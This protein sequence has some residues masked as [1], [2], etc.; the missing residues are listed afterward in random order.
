MNT[1]RKVALILLI[2]TTA[3]QAR[4]PQAVT[5]VPQVA[6]GPAITGDLSDPVWQR[7]QAFGGF[8]LIKD[9]KPATQPTAAR[10][11]YDADYL[12]VG[13]TCHEANLTGIIAQVKDRDGQV[14][15]DDCIE[16]LLDTANSKRS[17][18]HFIVN[19]IG[20]LFDE[21]CISADRGD[22]SWD[23]RAVVKTGL[24]GGAWTVEM[25]IPFKDLGFAPTPGLVWGMNICRARYAGTQEFSACYPTPD[26]FVQ[27]K[28]FG[29]VMLST[30]IRDFPSFQLLSWG[31]LD[32]DISYGGK[33]V[34]RCQIPNPGKVSKT[35]TLSLVGKDA[36]KTTVSATK[37]VK[38]P[39]GVLVTA[40]IPYSPSGKLTETFAFTIT[41]GR[42][43]VFGATHPSQAIPQK[44]RVW[45]T[46]DPLFTELLSENPPGLQKSGTIYW[47]HSGNAGELRPFA[48]EYGLRY[49]LDEAFR[50]LADNKLMPIVMTQ[51]LRNPDW[52]GMA[53]KHG[54]KVLFEPDYRRSHEKGVPVMDGLPYILDPRSREVYL[55]DLR[56]G[57]EAGRKFIWGIYTYDELTDYASAQ[58]VRFFSEQKDSY[59]FIREADA[60]VKA[61]F[62]Y[63]K[64]GIPESP[65]DENP[66]RWIAYHKW[67][68]SK[69][70]EWQKQ[71]YETLRKDAPEIKVISMDPVAGHKPYDLD[72]ITPYVDIATHQLYPSSNPN[73]QEFGFVTKFVA[74]LTGKPVWPCTHVENYA[75]STTAE[76]VRE[77]MSQVMRNGGKGFHLYIPDVRG[78]GASSGD[79]KLTKYGS[80]ERYRAIMEILKT[81]RSMNEVAVPSDA[82]CAI[83]YSEDHYQSFPGKNNIY[84]NEVEYCYT[85]LG[86]VART[87]FDI[88]ND[89]MVEDGKDLSK[90]KAIF[91]PAARYER[92][93]VVEKLVK[94]AEDGGVLVFS[95]T[96]P[97]VSA[98]DGSSLADICT[99]LTP[100][101]IAADERF[102]IEHK[103]G[104]GRTFIFFDAFT[105]K[106]I[107]DEGYKARFRALAKELGLK[108]D[109]DIWRFRFLE[110]KTVYQP[111]PTGRCLTGNYVKWHQEKPLDILNEPAGGVYK[112][113]A[114][115]DA[116]SDQGGE[117]R[118]GFDRGDLTDRKLAPATKKSDLKPEDFVV[119]WK[120]ERP[121]SVT[122]D[123]QKPYPISRVHL[124]YSDQLPA[125]TVEG[126]TDGKKWVRLASHP[127]QAPTKDV[128]D[129]EL[130]VQG[131]FRY[132]RPSF[133]P[134]DA[135]QMMTLVECEV[136]AK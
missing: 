4:S 114:A 94:Y 12:Y 47:F 84:P 34:L 31:N 43:T 1:L 101:M 13:V 8:R 117:V 97:F 107:G 134:R 61:R 115:P 109:R 131:T 123:L 93:S 85:L 106:N 83:L 19:S 102:P 10:V 29:E 108:T 49:S 78:G 125:L 53:E 121:V 20:T 67:V 2:L 52:L 30:G 130:K 81:S 39:A 104:K 3:A 128:L 57:L 68:N 71:V 92:R 120:T 127:K 16:F 132:V 55:E 90:Y 18:Y 21:R 112:Y 73:R 11:L 25:A 133:G 45:R 9:G 63:G 72:R 99:G 59:P 74:D 105:E 124:W 82:D 22:A 89:N 98:P 38:S 54:V 75:Y 86:P 28:S 17:C 42:K 136:W 44:P 126:S 80:P 135:G 76:E 58:G 65:T 110:F 51:Q 119:S 88:I 66:F 111:D 26:G 27:P 46:E 69:L 35:Y 36:G 113:N 40:E 15:A 7:G 70:L 77:L 129:V 122:F 62:G 96:H 60:E 33:N 32:S 37:T 64:Y 50:E 87:W 103:F 6:K 100:S 14:W 5:L 79:T 48:K 95:D 91:V 24:T 118:I 56:A 23:S 116:V 41:S